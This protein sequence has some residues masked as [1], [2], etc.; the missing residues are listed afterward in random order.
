MIFIVLLIIIL[1]IQIIIFL[2][3]SNI[4]KIIDKCN[5]IIHNLNKI[6]IIFIHK[7]RNINKFNKDF[8]NNL[9]SRL[10]VKSIDYQIDYQ[11][12]LFRNKDDENIK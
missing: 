2:N 7:R 5:N 12:D 10:I 4:I 11:I 3:E 6:K 8:I 9:K 1:I